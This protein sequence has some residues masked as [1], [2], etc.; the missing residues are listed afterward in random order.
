MSI[1]EI[2][3]FLNLIQILQGKL[4]VPVYTLTDLEEDNHDLDGASAIESAG[5]ELRRMLVW[6][7]DAEALLPEIN[8]VR[9]LSDGK[10]V[11]LRP[12]GLQG[13]GFSIPYKR[14]LMEA[15]IERPDLLVE[16][17]QTNDRLFEELTTLFKPFGFVYEERKMGTY[18]PRF[19]AP[20]SN[21]EVAF[22]HHFGFEV[23]ELRK[24]WRERDELCQLI[25]GEAWTYHEW[26]S[27]E[28]RLILEQIRDGAKTFSL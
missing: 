20:N 12:S 2:N 11:T 8:K 23:F 17:V 28:A 6:I 25:H 18:D 21:A 24:Q 16:V 4:G 19:Y 5:N 27:V 3:A 22:K 26:D 15:V 1:L 14:A 10:P 7:L 13:E 9:Q